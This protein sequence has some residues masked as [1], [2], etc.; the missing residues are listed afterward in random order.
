[1]NSREMSMRKVE[2]YI[3]LNFK[4]SKIQLSC[5]EEE[6]FIQNVLMQFYELI[7]DKED[8]PYLENAQLD[9]DT[10]YYIIKEIPKDKIC[11]KPSFYEVVLQSGAIVQIQLELITGYISLSTGS[12]VKNDIESLHKIER[13]LVI[14]RGITQEDIDKKSMIFYHYQ[15]AKRDTQ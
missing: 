13:E 12:N 7:F 3:E 9:L 14:C 11:L 1:M 10:M 15:L 2:K 6:I 4:G 5:M 8:I